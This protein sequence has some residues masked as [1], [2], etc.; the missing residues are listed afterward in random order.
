M[1]QP[2]SKNQQNLVFFYDLAPLGSVFKKS[3]QVNCS[4]GTIFA[5]TK[6]MISNI[7]THL[8]DFSRG[9]IFMVQ[10]IGTLLLWWRS[11]G[12][13]LQRRAAWVMT[14]L[15]LLSSINF[16]LYFVHN[17]LGHHMRPVVDLMQVTAI[18]MF[19]FLLLDLTRPER[20][21]WKVIALHYVPYVVAIAAFGLTQSLPVYLATI[22]LAM[23][24]AVGILIYGMWAVR[25]H[26]RLVAEAYSTLEHRD[27]RWLTRIW[28]LYFALFLVWSVSTWWPNNYSAAIFNVVAAILFFL[29]C[30]FVSRQEET[31]L[32]VEPQPETTESA[33]VD[34]PA[35]VTYHFA[36]RFEAAFSEHHLHLNPQLSIIDLAAEMGTNRTYVSNY[37]NQQL[38]TTFSNYV[39]SWRVREAKRLLTETNLTLEQVAEQSGF[40]SLTSFRRNFMSQVGMTPGSYRTKSGQK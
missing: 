32:A 18:P 9:L 5:P 40:N 30:H 37:I 7:S 36:H 17:F 38:H 10:L 2:Q 22:L 16:V 35:E 24:H 25:R 8:L 31:A 1:L 12:H 14:Y 39:N 6:K 27:L 15:L 26:D 19:L 20:L 4:F 3:L 33:P 34:P 29:L 13:R 11:P 23:A 21:T 28:Q